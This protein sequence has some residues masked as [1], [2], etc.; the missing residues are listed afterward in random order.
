MGAL[1]SISQGVEFIFG[2]VGI[3]VFE[4][5]LAAQQAGIKFIGMRNEQA[6]CYAAGAMGYLTRRPGVCLV[7]SGPGLVHALGGLANAQVN[8]WP[9][10][11]VGGSCEQSVE[12]L[13]AFQE[14]QQVEASRNYTKYACRPS[15]VQ[16]I[17]VHVEKVICFFTLLK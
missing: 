2:V 10:L 1:F 9:L 12:G 3:P 13:G 5:A 17:P 7:V 15:S 16:L 8:G 6:A 14:L 4:V 11:L